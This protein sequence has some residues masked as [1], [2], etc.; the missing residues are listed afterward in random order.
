MPQ[1][2]IPCFITIQNKKTIFNFLLSFF[3]IVHCYYNFT[4]MSIKI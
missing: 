1:M 4:K 2:H 3:L